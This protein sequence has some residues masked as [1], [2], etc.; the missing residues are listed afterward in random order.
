MLFAWFPR[1]R[2]FAPQLSQGLGKAIPHP[3]LASYVDNVSPDRKSFKNE[4]KCLVSAYKGQHINLT[5][6]WQSQVL[7]RV[8]W[9]KQLER[10]M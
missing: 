4:F 2:F 6:T 10:T 8:P 5:V 7:I 1:L 3:K 9:L